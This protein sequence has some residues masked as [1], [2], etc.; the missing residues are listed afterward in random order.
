MRSH[1][2]RVRLWYRFVRRRARGWRRVC[3][4]LLSVALIAS[5]IVEIVMK[6]HGDGCS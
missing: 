2:S 1:V 5:R 6:T 4:G 3:I